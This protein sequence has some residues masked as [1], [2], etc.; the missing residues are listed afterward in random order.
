MRGSESNGSLLMA[1][2]MLEHAK[3]AGKEVLARPDGSAYVDVKVDVQI[4]MQVGCM[5]KQGSCIC[6]YCG[7]ELTA[8]SCTKHEISFAEVPCMCLPHVS[9]D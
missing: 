5:A 2:R 7:C 4:A 3:A 9:Q 8:T 6:W 1:R